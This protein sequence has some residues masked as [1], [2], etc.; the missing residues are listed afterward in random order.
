MLLHSDSM[1]YS[2]DGGELG[3]KSYGARG[4]GEKT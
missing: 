4:K 1:C 3:W 2:V